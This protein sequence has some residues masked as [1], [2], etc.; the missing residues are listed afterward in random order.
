[1]VYLE[2]NNVVLKVEECR[3]AEF[4]KE[5]FKKCG[6]KAKKE[7]ISLKNYAKIEKALEKAKAEVVLKD[8]E[9]KKLGETIDLKDKEIEKLKAVTNPKN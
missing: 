6:E 4:E 3:V 5:G 1:M 2:R 7:E 9:I 8:E